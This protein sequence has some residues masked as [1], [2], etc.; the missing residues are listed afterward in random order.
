[1]EDFRKCPI[2]EQLLLPAGFPLEQLLVS[3]SVGKSLKYRLLMRLELLRKAW[4]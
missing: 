1:M 2:T 4:P 3:V